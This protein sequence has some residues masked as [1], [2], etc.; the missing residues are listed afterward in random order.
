MAVIRTLPDVRSSHVDKTVGFY[1][2]F[3]GFDVRREGTSITS[4]VSRTDPEVEVT[5]NH[6]AFALPEGFIVE[7]AEGEVGAVFERAQTVGLRIVEE[8]TPDGA[9]F[10]LLDPNG[11][12]V[13]VASASRRPRLSSRPRSKATITAA[14]AGV[15]TNNLGR[16]RDFYVE[17]LGFEM[18]WERDGM[19]QL[20][21][22]VSGRAEL[23][24]ASNSE[25]T[26]PGKGF[27][28]GVGTVERLE[29]LHRAAN[30]NWIVMGEPTS[31]ENV[32]IRCFVVLDPSSTPINLYAP[33]SPAEIG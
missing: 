16:T 30:G 11:C 14:L 17:L 4:F 28:L 27:D 22:P 8:P 31:F 18:G 7:V 24:L 25:G 1:T 21:S 23:I 19:A 29:E 15:T 33:L 32:G 26:G 6:G 20:R 12:C 10:S 13:T 5:L 9:C 2:E 3:L